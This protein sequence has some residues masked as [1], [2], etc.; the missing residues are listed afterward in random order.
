MGINVKDNPLEFAIL[1]IVQNNI[2][3]F[4]LSLEN[5]V[6]AA[7]ELYAALRKARVAFTD[8]DFQFALMKLEDFGALR[9]YFKNGIK[10]IE[11][12]VAE[13]RFLYNGLL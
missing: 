11:F 6:L 1:R 8:T 12:T 5:R 7:D 2:Q 10:M 13:M 9:I 3:Y 4:G